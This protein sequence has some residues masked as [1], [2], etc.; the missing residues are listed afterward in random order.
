MNDGETMSY[1][2]VYGGTIDLLEEIRFDWNNCWA[3][4]PTD[5]R[6]YRYIQDLDT[7]EFVCELH[8]VLMEKSIYQVLLS[9]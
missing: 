1:N 5:N 8:I 7:K 3:N 4:N 2:H 9:I 6:F